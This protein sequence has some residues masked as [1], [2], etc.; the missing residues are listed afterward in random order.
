MNRLLILTLLLLL[1]LPIFAEDS[2][3]APKEKR[4][5]IR[6]D[7]AKN[8]PETDKPTTMK[9]GLIRIRRIRLEGDPL[10]PKYGITQKFLKERLNQVYSHMDEYLNMASINKIADSITLAYREKGLTFNRAFVVPQEITNSTLTIHVLKGVLS[11]IDLY[12]NALYSDKQILSPFSQL[13]GKVIYEPEVMA[14]VDSLNKKPGLKVFGYFSLG[15]KQGQSRL[16]IKVL[17]ET[18][19]KSHVSLDNKGISQTGKN[20]ILGSHTLNNPLGKSGR[21]TAS[22][23]KTNQEGNTYGGLSY[24]FPYSNTSNVGL[25]LVKSDFTI[26]GEFSDLG[27]EGSLTSFSGF[28]SNI[29]TVHAQTPYDKHHQIAFSYKTSE[30][31]SDA[32]PTVFDSDLQYLLVHGAYRRHYLDKANTRHIL[33]LRPAIGLME[34]TGNTNTSD[35]FIILGVDYQFLLFNWENLITESNYLQVKF[36]GQWSEDKLPDPERFS[37]TGPTANRGYKPGIFSGDIGYNSTIEQAFRW[38]ADAIWGSSSLQ[39]QASVFIDYSYGELNTNES[40]YASFSSAGITLL[41][42]VDKQYSIST[43]IGMP[44]DNSSSSNLEIDSNSPVIYA[45]AKI[46]F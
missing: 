28:F 35:E 37:T 16:N 33:G 27:L 26:S 32:F 15:S 39:L 6:Y 19:G 2:A 17:K 38:D 45:S 40:Y 41:G 20:R 31:K 8:E 34:T 21:F 4:L 11:E 46:N 22:V 30:I 44:I 3:S 36:K 43:S 1:P 25:S 24:Y 7:A 14:I 12:D 10:Y 42:T 29:S 13:I 18:H 9:N 23:I 5:S